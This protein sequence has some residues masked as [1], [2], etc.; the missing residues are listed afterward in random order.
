MDY[1]QAKEKLAEVQNK[2]DDLR[3]Q[4][5]QL[6]KK[7]KRLKKKSLFTKEARR[8]IFKEL[9]PLKSLIFPLNREIMELKKL[10]AEKWPKYMHGD[11]NGKCLN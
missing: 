7:I 6:Q 2:R 11:H 5:L 8:E 3:H 4:E 1:L 9:N 10:A